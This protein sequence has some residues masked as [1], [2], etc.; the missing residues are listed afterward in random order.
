MFKNTKNKWDVDKEALLMLGFCFLYGHGWCILAA[1][2]RSVYFWSLSRSKVILIDRTLYVCRPS[3]I[4][5]NNQQ[6]ADILKT[7]LISPRG[8]IAVTKFGNS[9]LNNCVWTPSC[10][11]TCT[12]VAGHTVQE[13]DIGE[14][15]REGGFEAFWTFIS[16]RWRT[17]K[18]ILMVVLRI[19]MACAGQSDWC[20]RTA[21]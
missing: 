9:S 13:C 20:S 2:W 14:M 10:L 21:P 18:R 4:D 3:R 15:R 8:Q 6:P 19:A 11:I 17:K 1:H 7:L 12:E 16:N 5:S